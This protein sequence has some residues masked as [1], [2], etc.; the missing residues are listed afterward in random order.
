MPSSVRRAL[1]ISSYVRDGESTSQL[2]VHRGERFARVTPRLDDSL[3]FGQWVRTN[4]ERTQ[5][6]AGTFRRVPV[7]RKI[8]ELR[9]ALIHQPAPA[10]M[11]MVTGWRLTDAEPMAVT[12]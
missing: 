10:G 3:I 12:Y 1:P 6:G 4:Y 2:C 8:Q 9:V 7:S 11:G 5:E